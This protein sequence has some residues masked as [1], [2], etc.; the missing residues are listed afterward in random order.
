LPVEQAKRVCLL[1][2]QKEFAC[3]SNKEGLPVDQAKRV[4]LL[5]KQRE[6]ACG[7]NKEEFAC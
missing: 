1:I 5:I 4:C 6:F 7:S 3:G 2:K